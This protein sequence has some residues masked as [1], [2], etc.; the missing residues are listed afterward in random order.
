LRRYP[1][2]WQ[3][4]NE[5]SRSTSLLYR[6]VHLA[7]VTHQQTRFTFGAGVGALLSRSWLLNVFVHLAAQCVEH[8]WTP[9]RFAEELWRHLF[10]RECPTFTKGNCFPFFC[11]FFYFFLFFSVFFLFFSVFFL[12]PKD[13]CRCL[14]DF[15][16]LNRLHWAIDDA[17]AVCAWLE[18]HHRTSGGASGVLLTVQQWLLKSLDI[19]ADGSHG[20]QRK[21]KKQPVVRETVK[22][23]FV[24]HVGGTRCVTS[25]TD[26]TMNR[27]ARITLK[28]AYV[29]VFL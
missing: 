18:V 16:P 25:S 12:I 4:G 27:Q 20:S 10:Q 21:R 15:S 14:T 26:N 11:F 28:V 22:S 7:K 9:P 8:Q 29:H 1:P 23:V 19:A 3:N 6:D 24:I 5:Q 17:R 13:F 2:P